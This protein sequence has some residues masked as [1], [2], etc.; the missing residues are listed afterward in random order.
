MKALIQRVT[1]A[2]VRVDGT[3]VAHISKGILIFLGVERGDGEKESAYLAE[4]CGGLRIFGD[5]E[6]K[7]NLSVQEVGG[8]VLV[9]SQFTLCA[10]T[11]KGKRPSFDQ[12]APREKAEELLAHFVSELRKMGISIE[13]GVFGAH[14]E[15]GLVNDGPVTIWLSSK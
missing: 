12:A 7:M 2:F 4:K 13:E 3:D 6:G 15:V 5:Q 11:R 8:G 10:D 1:E 9:V 14:M